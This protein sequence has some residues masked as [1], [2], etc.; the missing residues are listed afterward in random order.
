M[1]APREIQNTPFGPC[2]LTTVERRG[3]SDFDSKR[4]ALE[5][6]RYAPDARWRKLQLF[7]REGRRP[8]R[9]D[10]DPLIRLG[11]RYMKK[12]QE[13]PL[14]RLSGLERDFPTLSVAHG[15]H[16]AVEGVKWVLEGGIL[17]DAAEEDLSAYL[18]VPVEAIRMYEAFFYDMRRH[19][20][21]RGYV[22]AIALAPALRRGIDPQ[23]PDFAYKM[24]GFGAGW[25]ALKTFV[26]GQ[27]MTPA[28][29]SL[30]HSAFKAK[31][32]KNAWSAA[33][34]MDINNYNALEVIDRYLQLLGLE[35]AAG[36]EEDESSTIRMMA[37]VLQGLDMKVLGPGDKTF[38]EEPRLELPRVELQGNVLR[39]LSGGTDRGKVEQ[40]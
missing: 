3:R 2:T 9:N 23:D 30:F 20:G 29:R 5:E 4:A 16:T 40:K 17:A 24:L 25:D 26:D 39:L 21:S 12:Y 11:W 7:Y 18:D 22:L 36:A 1:V 28:A 31:L 38:V 27:D 34:R 32:L 13:T 6:L 33:Q 8:A 15:L 19:L 37:D 35:R 14:E 10:P